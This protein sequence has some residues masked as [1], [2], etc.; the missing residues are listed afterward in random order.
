MDTNPISVAL[1][2]CKACNVEK[3]VTAFPGPRRVCK[4]CTYKIRHERH[5][6]RMHTDEAY[7]KK[8]NAMLRK[9]R[10]KK[11]HEDETHRQR[12]IQIRI[13]QKQKKAEQRR[14]IKDQE[15]ERIG[16]DNK[17]CKYCGDV[18]LKTQFRHNRLK[19]KDCERDEPIEKL[20]RYIRTRIYICLRNK[21]KHKDQHTIEYLGCTSN[22]YLAYLLWY[23]SSFTLENQGK[24]WHID[25]VIP[26]S[27]FDLT[28]EEEKYL[29]FNWRNTMPLSK[30]ENL[31]KCN[32]ISSE[33]VKRHLERL[34][35]YHD[36]QHIIMP[37]AFNDLFAKHLVAGTP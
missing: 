36:K 21:N 11:Y 7:R 14:L 8:F 12:I 25:H 30:Y 37:Q 4:A 15:Q 18:K 29:A 34:D 2:C 13:K 28:N 33:Q 26:V 5:K 10:N 19:C 16:L 24:E 3:D 22:E 31:A 6:T 27:K 20:K 32:R 23:D 17:V 35:S 9:S 1:K